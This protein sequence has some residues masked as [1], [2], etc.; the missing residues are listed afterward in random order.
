MHNAHAP[1]HTDVDIPHLSADEVSYMRGAFLTVDR[2]YGK[3]FDWFHH[4]IG[5]P[6]TN[7]KPSPNPN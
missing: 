2:P 6:E 5:K 3:I 1:Q 7:P 4:Q